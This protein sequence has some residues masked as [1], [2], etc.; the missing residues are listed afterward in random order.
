LQGIDP[1]DL[2]VPTPDDAEN[3]PKPKPKHTPHARR[4]LEE[5][6]HLP[7]E[8]IVIEP[9]ELPEGAAKIGEDV[10][11]KLEHQRARVLRLKIVR[12]IY[13]VPGP[14]DATETTVVQA[15]PVDEMIPK[16]LL[17]PGLLAHLQSQR[18]SR[19]H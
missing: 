6:D 19:T 3:K 7:T 9:P 13:A 17:A 2:P 15:P 12:P 11:W 1:A 5:A 18:V 16:G 10:S 8:T 14:V 4:N